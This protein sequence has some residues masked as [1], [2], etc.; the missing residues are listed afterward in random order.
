MC[1]RLCAQHSVRGAPAG[2]KAHFFVNPKY[3]ELVRW[4]Q[5]PPAGAHALGRRDARRPKN[6]SSTSSSCSAS[7]RWA[8]SGRLPGADSGPS[9]GRESWQMAADEKIAH[10]ERK[11]AQG[12]ELYQVCG[13]AL[14]GEVQQRHWCRWGG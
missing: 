5:W 3:N 9:Q 12:N 6:Q 14:V 8:V 1:H 13:A 7:R 11:K 10:A 2:E 4:P